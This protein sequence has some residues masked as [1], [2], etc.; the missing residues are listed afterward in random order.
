MFGFSKDDLLT[1]VEK[2]LSAR[3]SVR[4]SVRP[5]TIKLNGAICAIVIWIEVDETNRTIWLSRSSKVKV[6]VTEPLNLRKS[7]FSK[8]ISFAI[9]VARLNMIIAYD[10]M[11]QYLNFVESNFWIFVP[12]T[13]H[14]PPKFA[15]CA[16]SVRPSF[17]IKPHHYIDLMKPYDLYSDMAR[18]RWEKSNHMIIKLMKM[19]II[20]NQTHESHIK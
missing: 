2:C 9:S 15:F 17:T 1:L 11:G 5:L 6:K 13:C 7:P 14:V 4:L 3:P 8:S 19:K 10:T 16:M 12:F 18:R 20:H